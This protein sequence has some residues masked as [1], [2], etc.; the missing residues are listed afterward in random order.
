M[1]AVMH[2]NQKCSEFIYLHIF[3]IFFFFFFFARRY[4]TCRSVGNKKWQDIHLSV[5]INFCYTHIGTCSLANVKHIIGMD[6]LHIHMKC[7]EYTWYLSEWWWYKVHTMIV[8]F[9][10]VHC[11]KIT[12][13][14][15]KH[16]YLPKHHIIFYL[17]QTK[18]KKKINA[19]HLYK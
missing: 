19:L 18:K 16:A 2:V 17:I 11:N 3:L 4:L 9:I 15:C 10:H 7:I 8:Y 1:Y 5:H 13:I 6:I 12:V 14:W